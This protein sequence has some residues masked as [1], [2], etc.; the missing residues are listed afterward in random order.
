[1]DEVADQSVDLVVTSPPYWNA[2]DYEQHVQDPTAWYRTRR[3]GPYEEYLTWL[4]VCFTETFKKQRDGGICCAVIGTV[5]QNGRQYA[6]PQHLTVMLEEIG[7]QFIEEII[8]H[9]VTGGVKRAGVTIQKPYPGY[10]CPNIMTESILIFQKPGEKIYK[11]RD[12]WEKE[13]NKF[14]IDDIFTREIANN[15]WHIAPVPPN[16]LPHP[17][18]FPEEIPYR[19]IRLYS[20]EEDL[21]L[22]PF[23]GIGTTA[24]VAKALGRKFVGYDVHQT[25]VD[26]AKKRLDESLHLRDQLIA[27]FDKLPVKDDV[28]LNNHQA[29]NSQKGQLGLPGLGAI[30]E[31]RVEYIT[32]AR[33]VN[34][35]QLAKTATWLRTRNR[36]MVISSDLDGILSGMLLSWLWGWKLV[37]FYDAKKLWLLEPFGKTWRN[38]EIAFVDHDINLRNVP[39]VGHHILQH[40]STLRSLEHSATDTKSVNP[41]LLLDFTFLDFNHK[42]PFGTIHFL[43]CC[44]NAWKDLKL[45]KI[46][47]DF[48]PLLLHVDS[49]LKNAVLY[50]SNALDWLRWLGEVND[51]AESIYPLC[52]VI[53]HAT[54]KRLLEGAAKVGDKFESL[55]YGRGSQCTISNPTKKSVWEKTTK[56]VEWIQE[57]S[58]WTVEWP[59]F[60]SE[61][62]VSIEMQVHKEPPTEQDF[63][64]MLERKP[65]SYAITKND[66]KNKS[67]E[68]LSYSLIKSQS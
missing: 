68:G 31:E 39:S 21:V 59:D 43:L 33:S 37:G 28:Y 22:D 63:H 23:L 58:G 48:V 56:L 60:S 4:R 30:R 57:I 42:Y 15:V 20:Y 51:P 9:K 35:K 19:L 13:S 54:P 49:A 65:F 50:Q 61:S 36:K 25:Y 62:V 26:F 6:V 40:S 3:G 10:Y 53:S 52:Y 8:W 27:R 18:P 24:K 5:L 7:Y 45:Y 14:E 29:A 34:Y 2:I 41:N 44:Y 55:G 1:M 66:A 12:N 64:R 47:K 32:K 17:C 67:G 46:P 38:G 11:E 16:Y